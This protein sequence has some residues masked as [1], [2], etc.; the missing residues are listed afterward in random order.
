MIW[1]FILENK[2]I[3]VKALD[4]QVTQKGKRQESQIKQNMES[5]QN[6]VVALEKRRRKEGSVVSF[7]KVE[8]AVEKVGVKV[9]FFFWFFNVFIHFSIFFLKYCTLIFQFWRTRSLITIQFII[10]SSD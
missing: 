1:W 3:Q 10:L 5:L 2:F 8:D 7:G 4:T 9:F 6:G